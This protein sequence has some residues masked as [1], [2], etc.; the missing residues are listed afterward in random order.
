MQAE[1]WIEFTAAQ[2]VNP[3]RWKTSLLLK[4]PAVLPYRIMSW[5][6][7]MLLKSNRMHSSGKRGSGQHGDLKG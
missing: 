2:I 1:S 7:P 5:N 3:A 4:I 6:V